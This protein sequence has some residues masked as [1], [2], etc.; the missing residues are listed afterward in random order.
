MDNTKKGD[1]FGSSKLKFTLTGSIV[2]LGFAILV[3]SCQISSAIND[4]QFIQVPNYEDELNELNGQI[5]TLTE[6]LKEKEK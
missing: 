1:Q 3:G 6:V 2:F 5:N 4:L